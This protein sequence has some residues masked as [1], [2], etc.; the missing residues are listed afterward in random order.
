MGH[1]RSRHRHVRLEL[2]G[3]RAEEGDAERLQGL[4]QEDRHRRQGQHGRPQHLPGEHQHL[5]AG[6]AGRRLHV[7][8]RLPDAVLRRSR[9]SPAT[10]RRRL[11]DDRRGR[12]RRRFK[13]ASTG[14]D[15]KQ[16]FVPLLQL[17][18]GGLLPEERVQGQGL[19]RSRRP[20]DE[21]KALATQMKTDGLTPIAFA[22]KDGWPAMGTFDILNMR[23]NG[24]DFHV[25]PDG[26]QGVVGRPKVK[27]VFDTWKR[28]PAA[29]T[30][31]ARSGRPGRRRRSSS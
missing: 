15:G 9:A 3:R 25:E 21:L 24:Y 20:C 27:K 29:S 4:H 8:R 30:G 18:V 17:P 23:V 31:R 14:D 10:D 28:A 13:T 6:Q 5:P 12:C 7:V 2:L 22:D 19:R 11:E 16:Y 1:R 26:G